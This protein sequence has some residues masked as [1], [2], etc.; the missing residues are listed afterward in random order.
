MLRVFLIR[1]IALF[2]CSAALPDP[3][4]GYKRGGGLNMPVPL[5]VALPTRNAMKLKLK[6]YSLVLP[7]CSCIYFRSKKYATLYT[8]PLQPVPGIY[9][10]VGALKESVTQRLQRQ[11]CTQC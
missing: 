7:G 10:V 2:H 9:S 8:D 6:R 4:A 3:R 11:A 1:L 5:I